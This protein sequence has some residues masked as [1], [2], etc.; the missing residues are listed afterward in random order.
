MLLT[1]PQ[2]QKFYEIYLE[3]F[4]EFFNSASDTVKAFSLNSSIQIWHQILL[5]L[6]KYSLGLAVIPSYTWGSLQPDPQTSKPA[7]S[8]QPPIPPSFKHSF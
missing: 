3:K 2:K 1:N 5:F 6:L 8:L 7:L 4:S